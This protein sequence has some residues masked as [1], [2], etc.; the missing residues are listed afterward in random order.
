[1]PRSRAAGSSGVAL[2]THRKAQEGQEVELPC[3]YCPLRR[4]RGCRFFGF[5][6]MLLDSPG[7][8]PISGQELASNKQ[9]T[10]NAK[11][12]G[13]EYE[14]SS[15]RL[16]RESERPQRPSNSSRRTWRNAATVTG[17]CS[18]PALKGLR[19]PGWR[20]GAGDREQRERSACPARRVTIRGR[21]MS[22]WQFDTQ[23]LKDH[24]F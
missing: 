23:V 14:T 20:S 10:T 8:S 7:K 2:P 22:L 15:H 16:G 6:S 18:A 21:P 9:N 19:A 24:P 5:S 1:M 13:H 17:A 12:H 4:A 3:Y 11:C